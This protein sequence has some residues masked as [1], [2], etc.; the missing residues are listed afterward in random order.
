[1]TTIILADDSKK[2]IEYV[3]WVALAI[4]FGMDASAMPEEWDEEILVHM[5][6]NFHSVKNFDELDELI[7]EGYTEL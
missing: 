6:S 3:N 7:G 5:G 1:M 2:F 4:R